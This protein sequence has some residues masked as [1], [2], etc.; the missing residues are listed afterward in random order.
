MPRSPSYLMAVSAALL[1]VIMSGCGKEAI[2]PAL[3]DAPDGNAEVLRINPENPNAVEHESGAF[4]DLVGKK[5]RVV[6]VEFWGPHCGPCVH[7]APE[8]DKLAQMYPQSLSIVKVDVEKSDNAELS[9][10]FGIY[11]IPDLRVFVNGQLA[12]RFSGYA[13]ARQLVDLL[14]PHI[15]G[16]KATSSL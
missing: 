10:F 13:D 3:T 11:A 4:L 12:A 9:Q 6:L 14:H 7:M 1:T 5:D 8:L 16:L 2:L 15:E